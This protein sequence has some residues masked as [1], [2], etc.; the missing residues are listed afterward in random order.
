MYKLAVFDMDG[1]VLN[2]KHQIP[3]ENKKAFKYLTNL[4]IR[5]VIATGRPQELLK[6]YT[7]ELLTTEYT[8][9]CNGSVIGRPSKDDFIHE[10]VIAQEDVI[11]LIDMCEEYNYDYLV[12]TSDAV[13]SKDNERL[14][15]FRKIGESYK[16]EDK[17]KIIQ[18]EDAD[19]I[20]NNFSPNKILIMEKD[21]AEYLKMQDRIKEFKNVESAQSWFGALDISPLGDNKGSAVKKVCEHYNIL[22]E[23][24]IA[25]GDNLNDMSMIKYAG[26][27]V[28]MGNAEEELKSIADYV[29][30]TNDNDGV[31]KAIYK[32]IK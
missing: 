27:G 21:P 5:I 16:E 25:F 22:P 12:Y 11:N 15:L 13:V 4:G 30:D 10:N 3:E 32:F 14:R 2:S 28:A 20:K 18:I 1:T 17:A 19:Y 9:T 31:A 7:N 26:L 23:E 8:I 6:K 29:T 24:V